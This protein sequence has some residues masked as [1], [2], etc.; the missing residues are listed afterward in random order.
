MGQK[1]EIPVYVA[2]GDSI[3]KGEFATHPIGTINLARYTQDALSIGTSYTAIIARSFAKNEVDYQNLGM[4][5]AYAFNVW[6][7][8]LPLIS[9]RAS[10]VTVF[11]G[12]NDEI[13]IADDGNFTD[14]GITLH[15]S[16]KYWRSA[17]HSKR[18]FCTVLQSAPRCATRLVEIP[19]CRLADSMVAV[20][21]SA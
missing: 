3:T 9:P 13:S 20:P 8:A 11:I 18:R 5:G 17:L 2:I 15:A 16:L 21:R 14:G 12:I 4:N 1:T 7:D 6:D 10:I 19:R